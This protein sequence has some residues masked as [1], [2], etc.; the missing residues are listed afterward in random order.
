MYRT[1]VTIVMESDRPLPPERVELWAARSVA[2][3]AVSLHQPVALLPGD[4]TGSEEDWAYT[5][6]LSIVAQESTPA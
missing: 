3:G 6:P 1:S 5:S 4:S 2:N